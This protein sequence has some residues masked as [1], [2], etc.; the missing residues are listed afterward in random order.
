MLVL[1]DYGSPQ[2]KRVC[3]NLHVKQADW[4][5]HWHFVIQESDR[6]RVYTALLLS[7]W[8]VKDADFVDILFEQREKIINHCKVI[9][10][11]NK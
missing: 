1:L 8:S 10:R 5:S 3:N 6:K 9:S 2:Y 4:R 11:Y 7:M